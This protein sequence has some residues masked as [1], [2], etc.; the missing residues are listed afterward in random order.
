MPLQKVVYRF[1]CI[2]WAPD[3]SYSVILLLLNAAQTPRVQ[4]EH[5]K[6]RAYGDDGRDHVGYS[7][8]VKMCLT[9]KNLDQELNKIYPYDSH[10]YFW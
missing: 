9:G 3:V 8:D 1:P 10:G 6:L 7:G 4:P 5:Q 2:T